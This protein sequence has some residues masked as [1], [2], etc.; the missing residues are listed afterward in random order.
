M[1]D[2]V[3]SLVH[4]SSAL[5]QQP[6]F[7]CDLIVMPENGQEARL[8]Q[9]VPLDYLHDTALG[10]HDRYYTITLEYGHEEHCDP[11]NIKRF[12]EQGTLSHFIHPVIRRF[13]NSTMLSEYH[14]PEDLENNWRQDMYI[15]PFLE[16]L[17]KE[18]S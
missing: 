16:F 11:F 9:H 6:A 13:S 15:Q 3:M 14:I 7:F 18:M 5:F 8:Y 12:P 4:S 17:R 2:V 1:L 10:Q